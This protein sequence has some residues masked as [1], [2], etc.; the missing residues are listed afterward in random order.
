MLTAN[1]GFVNDFG[2]ATQQKA[3]ASIIQRVKL[4][5]L[6]GSVETTEVNIVKALRYKKGAARC[7]KPPDSSKNTQIAAFTTPQPAA[8]SRWP[9]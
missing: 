8:T 1:A 3:I 5:I 9:M 6:V 7:P 4:N 2:M